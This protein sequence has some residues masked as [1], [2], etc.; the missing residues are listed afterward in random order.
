MDCKYLRTLYPGYKFFSCNNYKVLKGIVFDDTLAREYILDLKEISKS[1]S[2]EIDF[3]AL[4]WSESAKAIPHYH[5]SIQIKTCPGNSPGGYLRI[6][7]WKPRPNNF[8]ARAS[9][10]RRRAGG[11]P[12]STSCGEGRRGGRRPA[13]GRGQ[14]VGPRG[15]APEQAAEIRRLA[16]DLAVASSASA[17]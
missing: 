3:E 13:R 14:G 1:N 8:R 11:P 9:D 7:Y 16:G 17:R 2:G 6:I 4:L 10:D 15:A 12:R 5:Y